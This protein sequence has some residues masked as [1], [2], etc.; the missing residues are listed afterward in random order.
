MIHQPSPVLDSHS[1]D[2]AK[3]VDSSQGI[4][5]SQQAMATA[6]FKSGSVEPI[7]IR[8]RPYATLLCLAV[9]DSLALLASVGISVLLKAFLESGVRVES[10]LRLLPLLFVFLVVYAAIGLY[11]IVALSPPEEL[12]RATIA[13]SVLFLFLGAAT[14]S[15]RGAQQ[16]FTW[17]LVVALLVSVVLF[18]LMRAC[19]RQ[20]LGSR[21][22]WGFPAVIFGSGAASAKIVRTMLADTAI[23]LKPVALVN[24]S[25]AGLDVDGVPVLHTFHPCLL[26]FPRR[27]KTYAVFVAQDTSADNLK[28]RIGRYRNDFSHVLIVPELTGIASLWVNSKRIG[29]VLGLEV[30]QHRVHNEFKRVL[31]IA[32]ALAVGVLAGPLCLALSLFGQLESPGPIFYSQRRIGLNGTPFHAYKF[33]SMVMNSEALLAEHFRSHPEAREEWQRTQKLK[34]DPRVTRVGRILRK[35]SMDELP[36][37][38]NV[39]RGEMSFVGPRPIVEDEIR[40]YGEDFDLY[41]RVR[42][43]I[44][45]L[46]QVS[47]RSDTTYEERVSLDAF[48]SRNWSVWLDLCI[49]FRTFSVVLFGK[50]AY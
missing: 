39:L 14:V 44:T 36:Q 8:N 42:G 41:K 17:T 38:W 2:Q 26:R 18:P 25:Y 10:Y 20:V 49:L 35:T 13:S 48:Y 33:R 30:S 5:P 3:I 37:I 47:G 15:V 46:W 45:G 9:T 27:C 19:T 24:D 34:N 28:A 1:P 43:G 50:G 4:D 29:G 11:S 32:L 22:W 40:H 6:A 16:L 21:P 12:R 23:G 7:Q 31:D